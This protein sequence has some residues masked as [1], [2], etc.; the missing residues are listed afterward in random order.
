MLLERGAHSDVVREAPEAVELATKGMLR[1]AGIDPPKIHDV[2]GIILEN[3]DRFPG[4]SISDLARLAGLSKQLRRDRELSFYGDIDFIPTEEYS[5]AD[6]ESAVEAARF[7]IG[8]AESVIG[9][10]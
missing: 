2:G 4:V 8:I 1:R 3:R 9:T 6:A 10:R 5:R 7:I